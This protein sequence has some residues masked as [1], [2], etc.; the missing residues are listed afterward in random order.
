MDAFLEKAKNMSDAAYHA[1]A[2][3]QIALVFTAALRYN[4]NIYQHFSIHRQK[5]QSDPAQN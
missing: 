1:E 3:A 2:G 4:T 5:R